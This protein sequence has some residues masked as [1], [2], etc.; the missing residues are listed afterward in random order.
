MFRE[1]DAWRIYD[2]KIANK[3]FENVE[4]LKSLGARVTNQNFMHE[5]TNSK[6]NLR[7][8]GCR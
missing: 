4:K 8:A 1:Q 6:I 5:E 2:M 3:F 7:N